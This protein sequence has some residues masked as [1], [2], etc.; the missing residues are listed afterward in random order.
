MYLGGNISENGRV[1]VKRRIQ[2]GTY[3]WINV[4]EVM[5]DRIISRKLKG[6]VLDSLVVPA[7]TCDLEKLAMSEL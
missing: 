6:E 2:A 7:S 3:A 1:E 4:E 5:M